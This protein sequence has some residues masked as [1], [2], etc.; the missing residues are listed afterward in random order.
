MTQMLIRHG[1][2]GEYL[3]RIGKEPI[4]RCHHCDGDWNTVQHTLEACPAWAGERGVLIREIEGDLSLPA[5]VRAIVGGESAW[6][7]FSSFCDRFCRRRRRP[8]ERGSEP[9]AAVALLLV[10]SLIRI[11]YLQ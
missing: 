11:V 10:S 3:C 4:A 5:V 9:R 8:K 2:F 6:K 7:T 1:C